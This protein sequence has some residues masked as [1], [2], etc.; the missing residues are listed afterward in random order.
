M[1]A[2]IVGT[3]MLLTNGANIRD[4]QDILGH[5]SIITTQRYANIPT[6]KL[7]GKR[8]VL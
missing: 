4:I 3:S 8:T 2:V 5:S 1:Y 6:K 7:S